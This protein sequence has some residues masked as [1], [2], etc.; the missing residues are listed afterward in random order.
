MAK[1]RTRNLRRITMEP[2]QHSPEGADAPT[3]WAT[4]PRGELERYANARPSDSYIDIGQLL[5]Q[6]R[7]TSPVRS[8]AEGLLGNTYQPA[9]PTLPLF[10]AL[11]NDSSHHWREQVV[12]AWAL[13]RVPL[14]SQE[15]DAAA[16]MLL[17]T[18]E[19][20]E[21]ETLWERFLRGLLWGYGTMLP[22][23]LVLSLMIC[24]SGENVEWAD[25]F[26]QMLFFMGSMASVL[27]IPMCVV[28]GRLSSGHNDMLRAA[29]AESLGRLH[30]I[31]SIGPL[32]EKLFDPSII[33]REAA[34]FALMQILPKLEDSDCAAID[35]QSVTRLSEALCHP[36]TLLVFKILEA[37]K[38]VGTGNTLPAVEKLS[39]EGKTK[40]LQETA[41]QVAVVLEERRR[42]E[43]EARHLMRPTSGP[44]H[45]TDNLMRATQYEEQ[46]EQVQTIGSATAPNEW[47]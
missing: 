43:R 42:K 24:R 46:T 13:A 45:R 6:F 11:A 14:D 8:I 35:Q 27:T 41:R 10:S 34:A 1:Q 12:A 37:L 32:A 39:R 15:R 16:G 19:R 9:T 31:E 2:M 18:L 36:N 4:P 22:L 5:T 33:V 44:E 21:D 30:V 3:R 38:K 17:E 47:L 23:C 40:Q 26:P 29:S 25:V 20:D 28:Y 7:R